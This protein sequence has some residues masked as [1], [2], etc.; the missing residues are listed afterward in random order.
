MKWISA[1][2][3]LLSLAGCLVFPVLHF[4]QKIADREFKTLFLLASLG[5]FV[6]ASSFLIGRNRKFPN[7]HE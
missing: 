6:F 7:R 5:W 2:L 4:F 1:A 3:S